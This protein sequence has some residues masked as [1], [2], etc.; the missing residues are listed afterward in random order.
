LETARKKP[1][2]A[3]GEGGS[4]IELKNPKEY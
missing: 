2:N 4:F 1:G 3:L